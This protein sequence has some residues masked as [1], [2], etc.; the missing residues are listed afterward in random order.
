MK[1]LGLLVALIIACFF[2]SALSGTFLWLLWGSVRSVTGLTTDPSWL[3]CVLF[4]WIA[5][6]ILRSSMEFEK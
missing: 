1:M 2:L 4:S 3:D 5:S 6:V